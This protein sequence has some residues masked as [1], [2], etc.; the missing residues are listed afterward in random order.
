MAVQS[1]RGAVRQGAH[2][3]G[4]NVLL[5]RR[6][7]RHLAIGNAVAL[8]AAGLSVGARRVAAGQHRGIARIK[9]GHRPVVDGAVIP[10]AQFDGVGRPARLTAKAVDRIDLHGGARLCETDRRLGIRL[11]RAVA[12][13]THHGVAAERGAACVA[14]VLKKVKL[15]FFVEQAFDEGQA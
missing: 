14:N 4:G 5:A 1:K 2:S 11:H 8:F 13:G 15:A 12:V 6:P 7:M 9:G 10:A 3:A